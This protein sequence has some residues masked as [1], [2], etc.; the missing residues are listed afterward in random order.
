MS[1]SLSNHT[2]DLDSKRRIQ[3]NPIAEVY[4]ANPTELL[5]CRVSTEHKFK[6]LATV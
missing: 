5:V 4:C 3:L 6:Y 1:I 2:N